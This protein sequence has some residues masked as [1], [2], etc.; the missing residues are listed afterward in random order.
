MVA[1]SFEP[2]VPVRQICKVR[3]QGDSATTSTLAIVHL[4][5]GIALDSAIAAAQTA[6][7]D[8]NGVFDNIGVFGAAGS[9]GLF[10]ALALTGLISR[11]EYNPPDIQ[12]NLRTYM[13]A[14]TAQQ[15]FHSGRARPARYSA[16]SEYLVH[17]PASAH[18]HVERKAVQPDSNTLLTVDITLHRSSPRFERLPHRFEIWAP[19]MGC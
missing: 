3:R 17:W 18:T 15:R 11:V 1:Y 19:L 8:I 13:S 12:I 7:L 6:G 14:N 16:T 10:K 2:L 5:E 4:A 9:P